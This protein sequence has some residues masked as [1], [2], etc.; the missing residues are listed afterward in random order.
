MY[1]SANL[2]QNAKAYNNILKRVS[3]Y[4][5]FKVGEAIYPCLLKMKDLASLKECGSSNS[6]FKSFSKICFVLPTL[7]VEDECLKCLQEKPSFYL[8]KKKIT[9]QKE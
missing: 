2:L 6:F 3:S 7:D 8:E 1:F 4:E 5:E 9:E